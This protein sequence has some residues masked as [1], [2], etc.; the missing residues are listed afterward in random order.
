MAHG[1]T[2][3]MIDDGEWAERQADNE[4]NTPPPVDMRNHCP[5]GDG[6]LSWLCLRLGHWEGSVVG[7]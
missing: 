7:Y 2:S 3:K 4:K 6:S 5:K 1:I